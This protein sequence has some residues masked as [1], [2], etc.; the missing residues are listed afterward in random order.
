MSENKTMDLKEFREQGFL[1][2][3]NRKFF[4]P[5]GLALAI[6]IQWPDDVTQ[7]EKDKYGTEE[8]HPRSKWF[9]NEIWDYRDDPEGMLFN[10]L[11]QN[12]INNVEKLRL[13]KLDVRKSLKQCSLCDENGIQIKTEGTTSV[14]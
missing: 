5:L 14:T 1:Q 3:V 11:D 2:E 12:K 6:G 10:E 4:H 8:N 7:E 13:S 9:L